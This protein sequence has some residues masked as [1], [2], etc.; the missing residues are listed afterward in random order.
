ME[1]FKH[2]RVFEMNELINKTNYDEM[3]PIEIV[4]GVDAEGKTTAKKLYAFLGGDLSNY[5]KW[6]K[7]NIANN[8]FAEE[9]IDFWAF[10]LH[11]EWGGQATV[12]YKLTASFAKKLAMKSH[13]KR[14]EDARNYFITVEEKLKEIALQ[15]QEYYIDRRIGKIIRRELTD[16]LKDSGI[17]N[18][19]HGHSYSTFTNLIYKLVLGMNAS[20]FRKVLGLHERANVRE[21]LNEFQLQQVAKLEKAVQSWI[22]C[23]FNY[24][25]I[26]QMLETK[27]LPVGKVGLLQ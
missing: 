18:K 10:V 4:L 1:K 25:E 9:N 27:A 22:D 13:T 3:T 2:R 5:A 19:M 6:T 11:D 23:G 20:R 26:K 8:E 17:D 12:D 15:N 21:H 16:A 7:R 14:G 24:N